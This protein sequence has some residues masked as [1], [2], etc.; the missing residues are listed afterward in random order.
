MW[1]NLRHKKYTTSVPLNRKFCITR[2]IKSLFTF[3]HQLFSVNSP[4][5]LLVFKGR[6]IKGS[7]TFRRLLT[8]LKCNLLPWKLCARVSWPGRRHWGTSF[9][10]HGWRS[11]AMGFW[12]HSNGT[13][14]LTHSLTHSILINLFI[15]VRLN[16]LLLLSPLVIITFVPSVFDAYVW[17]I[18][19]GTSK[20]Y[21]FSRHVVEGPAGKEFCINRNILKK[22]DNII[23]KKWTWNC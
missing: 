8:E 20:V 1:D 4:R 22:T 13:R 10:A 23:C 9:L 2:L 3:F 7:S 11:H 18:L 21:M 12:R 15:K 6:R 16:T 5:R 14:S 17:H 19:V